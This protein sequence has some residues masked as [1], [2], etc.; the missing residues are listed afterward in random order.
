[1]PKTKP[2]RIYLCS[3]EWI[4]LLSKQPGYVAVRRLIDRAD[5]G[6]FEIVGSELLRVEVLGERGLELVEN[7]VHTWVAMDRRAAMR[8]RDFRL[9][10]DGST[11]PGKMTADVIHAASASLA[12]VEA[13]ITSDGPCTEVAKRFG[14]FVCSSNEYP[15]DSQL[16]LMDSLAE[17]P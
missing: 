14:L 2:P 3:T 8:A 6:D 17:E 12:E 1:M 4:T 7:S 15:A 16:T 10:P 9:R 13:F 5:R 11:L